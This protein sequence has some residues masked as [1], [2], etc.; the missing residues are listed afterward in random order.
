MMHFVKLHHIVSRREQEF[1]FVRKDHR[2]QHV[3]AL[4]QVGHANTIAMVVED[5][6]GESRDHRIAHGILLVKKGFCESN[7]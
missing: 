4:R 2:L 6:E 5:I 1:L 3:Y 7:E